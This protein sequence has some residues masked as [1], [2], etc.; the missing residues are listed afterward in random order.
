[1]S[2]NNDLLSVLDLLR[3]LVEKSGEIWL[4][5]ESLFHRSRLRVSRQVGNRNSQESGRWQILSQ[6]SSLW[7]EKKSA[8][9]FILNVGSFVNVCL[10][11]FN[12]MF[13][14]SLFY[15]WVMTNPINV[16]VYSFSS[17]LFL[18]RIIILLTIISI[19]FK[20]L[21]FS[22]IINIFLEIFF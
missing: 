4:V 18:L 5:Q 11:I 8:R 15:L 9:F 16:F 10:Y 22:V 2:L 13:S 19:K 21:S 20:L 17:S 1:M 3:G 6:P 7:P 12:F 14:K